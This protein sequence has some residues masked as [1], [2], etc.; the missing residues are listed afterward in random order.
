MAYG[1]PDAD[2]APASLVFDFDAKDF[3][4]DPNTGRFLGR[5]WVD[6]AVWWYL[7]H[8]LGSVRSAP[9][10]GNSVRQIQGLNRHSRANTVQDRVLSALQPLLSRSLIR[11]LS[12]PV[13]LSTPGRILY[14]CNYV[15]LV[16]SK[17]DKTP[18]IAL[19]S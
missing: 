10:L 6:S 8:D 9:Q 5:H 13:D 1:I 3:K 15:N 11:V 2:R 16:T 18:Q 14:A 7:T 4:R 12:I 19:P 17:P